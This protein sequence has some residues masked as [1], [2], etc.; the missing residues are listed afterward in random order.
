MEQMLGSGSNQN[1]VAVVNLVLDDLGRKPGEGFPP[2]LE[3]LILILHFDGAVPL[4]LP[5][6]GE[7]EAALLRGIGPERFRI[8]GLNMREG[9]P[10]LRNT[11]IRLDTPIM[12]AAMPTHPSAWAAKVSKR[13]CPTG[14]SSAVAG[15]EGWARKMG[16][17]IMGR[18]I[19]MPPCL[20]PPTGGVSPC[21]EW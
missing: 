3:G 6:A 21:P 12:L 20:T 14:R 4:G 19:G 16:S 7:G 15:A 5:P 9:P 17:F 8:L 10:S 11:M 2:G 18:T 1:P 13:S